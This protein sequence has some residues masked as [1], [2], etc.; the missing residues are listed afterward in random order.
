MSESLLKDDHYQQEQLRQ[1]Q[2]E[3]NP[4][5]AN[6]GE[7]FSISGFRQT[8]V[9]V[10]GLRAP[11]WRDTHKRSSSKRQW[12]EVGVNSKGH[13]VLR[14]FRSEHDAKYVGEMNIMGQDVQ[15]ERESN[16]KQD[17]AYPFCIAVKGSHLKREDLKEVGATLYICPASQRDETILWN[18][19]QA[20]IVSALASG[21]CRFA[22]Q[23]RDTFP[24]PLGAKNDAALDS[25]SVSS[26]RSVSSFNS[27][28]KRLTFRPS[29]SAFRGKKRNDDSS[30]TH[31][32]NSLDHGRR[33]SDPGLNFASLSGYEG[34]SEIDNVSSHLG[35]SE[36][37]ELQTAVQACRYLF[38][39]KAVSMST[40]FRRLSESDQEKCKGLQERILSNSRPNFR[41]CSVELVAGLLAWSLSRI[42]PGLIDDDIFYRYQIAIDKLTSLDLDKSNSHATVQAAARI[43]SSLPIERAYVLQ[44]VVALYEKV[45]TT[46]SQCLEFCQSLAGL[47]VNSLK[48]YLRP[49]PSFPYG[50]LD[51]AYIESFRIL[52]DTL[53]SPIVGA[54]IFE[55][56]MSREEAIN[57]IEKLLQGIPSSLPPG[58]A[59]FQE[60]TTSSSATL[61]TVSELVNKQDTH[62]A[63]ANGRGSSDVE[64]M[65]SSDEG[66]VYPQYLAIQLSDEETRTHSNDEPGL[67]SDYAGSAQTSPALTEL[68]NDEHPKNPSKPSIKTAKVDMVVGPIYVPSST[69]LK[70]EPSKIPTGDT[71]S[72]PSRQRQAAPQ[73]PFVKRVTGV[74]ENRLSRNQHLV[75]RS[76]D[77]SFSKEHGPPPAIIAKQTISKFDLPGLTQ[78]D[79]LNNG[80]GPPSESLSN[81]ANQVSADVSLVEDR[82]V[83]LS[84]RLEWYRSRLSLYP[85][86]RNA[87]LWGREIEALQ[88]EL[89]NLQ[90]SSHNEFAQ[91]V[92]SA[93]VSVDVFRNVSKLYQRCKDSS[94]ESLIRRRS[95]RS[96][97]NGV[98]E[99]HI[100]PGFDDQNKIESDLYLHHPLAA[101]DDSDK[102]LQ[103]VILDHHTIRA[104][105]LRRD[106]QRAG[107]QSKSTESRS[108]E[109]QTSA[110]T[111]LLSMVE[112]IAMLRLELNEYQ[113]GVIQRTQEKA[114]EF[115]ANFRAQ[116]EKERPTHQ[117]Q[118]LARYSNS[119]SNRQNHPNPEL[120]QYT[121]Q[122]Q[123]QGLSAST[124]IWS[125]WISSASPSRT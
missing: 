70:Q 124:S 91:P 8:I 18:A 21:V 77:N 74:P 47:V 86:S 48:V 49:L 100:M 88:E 44:L 90:S 81:I 55:E 42:E 9:A 19:L 61:E 111:L 82:R 98:S 57:R 83:T 108:S 3:W 125:R 121:Q 64:N 120:A 46:D 56:I 97:A 118:G 52:F 20:L 16:K 102:L 110:D 38:D 37:R 5:A 114:R 28:R 71:G 51:Q 63:K 7:T 1:Q 87:V 112:E 58:N 89:S 11:F 30:E 15:L 53:R 80:E 12:V 109:A 84:R 76:E 67:F 35:K 65:A 39:A 96:M 10:R 32:I 95:A 72:I 13:C 34:V 41:N 116:A 33:P 107:I 40:L 69:T 68:T 25:F 27:L 92:P 79:H 113:R 23:V 54:P 26:D 103:K 50:Q 94:A 106:A 43:V 75:A 104:H 78:T 17:S 105:S 6:S 117:G 99:D 24:R 22:A 123:D 119:T 60:P 62:V 31:S 29:F 4:E 93:S 122:Q 45:G 14:Y 36:F 59:S 115:E 66:V 101:L 73:S 85:E 2:R